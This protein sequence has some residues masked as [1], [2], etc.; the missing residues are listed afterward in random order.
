VSIISTVDGLL[1]ASN[2]AAVILRSTVSLEAPESLSS[3]FTI[4]VVLHGCALVVADKEIF[5]IVAR[6]EQSEHA[7]VS[8]IA[9]SLQ[10]HE[11]ALLD[12]NKANIFHGLHEWKS[13]AVGFAGLVMEVHVER[14]LVVQVVA[15]PELHR[16]SP[17]NQIFRITTPNEGAIREQAGSALL[18]E[19]TVAEHR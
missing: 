7:R 15:G 9:D 4:V 10:D 5:L 8:S 16:H 1:I 17:G 6:S 18:V 13:T 19:M 11:V 12:G 14:V 3:Y 2:E